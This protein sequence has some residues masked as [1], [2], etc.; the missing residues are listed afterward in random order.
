MKALIHTLAAAAFA[1]SLVAA[2]SA[3]AG[4][5]ENV[6]RQICR[7]QLANVLPGAKVPVAENLS[8]GSVSHYLVWEG[9]NTIA[10]SNGKPASASCVLNMES[11]KLY[12]TVSG[13][14]YPAMGLAGLIATNA[15]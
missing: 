4:M 10:R 1:V 12:L 2:S 3:F 5:S 15:E 9:R 11:G 8:D 13:K 7:S 6:A 14:D